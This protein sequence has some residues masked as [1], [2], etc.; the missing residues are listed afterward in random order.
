VKADRF[1]EQITNYNP[2]DLTGVM[3]W[4]E[5]TPRYGSEAWIRYE[6]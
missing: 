1:L 2:Q 6:G 5:T 4:N 3:Y